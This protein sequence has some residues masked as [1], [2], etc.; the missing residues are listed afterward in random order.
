MLDIRRRNRRRRLDLD[1]S[2]AAAV[3]LDDEIDLCAVAIS[4]VSDRGLALGPGHLFDELH[5]DEGLEHRA[6]ERA[7][8][9]SEA[10]GVAAEQRPRQAGIGNDHLV[11]R[12]SLLVRL[13]VHARIRTTKPTNSNRAM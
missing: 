7:R 6:R 5:G 13:G 9:R 3:V 1:A 12:F 11:W 2:D 4:P 8:R 10:D